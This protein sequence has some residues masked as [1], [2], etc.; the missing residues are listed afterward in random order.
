MEKIDPKL[1]AR[2]HSHEESG[3][4]PPVKPKASARDFVESSSP[5]VDFSLTS[6]YIEDRVSNFLNFGVQVGGY[7]FDRL[8]VSARMVT[9]IEAVSDDYSQFS[10]F[11]ET[12]STSVRRSRSVSLLY[13]ASIGVVLGN[14]KGF[15]FGPSVAL[16]RTDVEDYGTAVELALPF[17]WTTKR[18]LRVGFELGLGHAV[19]GQVH[20][21]C[22]RSVSGIATS[23]GSS[24]SPRPNGTMVL[25][26]YYMGWSLGTL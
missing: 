26:Q 24:S 11:D 25:F 6:F 17:E 13:G 20:H 15:V 7:V 1:S 8:R 3:A 4:E 9:P 21:E 18:N 14:S 23:C 16:F 12:G 5:W 19:G 10:S 2:S 22:T